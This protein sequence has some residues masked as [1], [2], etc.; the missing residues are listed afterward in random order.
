MRSRVCNWR[1][2]HFKLLTE[3]IDFCSL[4]ARKLP[5]GSVRG[6]L[7]LPCSAPRDFGEGAP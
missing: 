7:E 1:S 4:C 5:P 2:S 6:L 3:S